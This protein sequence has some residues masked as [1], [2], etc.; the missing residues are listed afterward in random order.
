MASHPIL[1][2]IFLFGSK[3]MSDCEPSRVVKETGKGIYCPSRWN[4]CF[5]P[6]GKRVP[7]AQTIYKLLCVDL[8]QSDYVKKNGFVFVSSNWEFYIPVFCSVACLLCC[9]CL[10]PFPSSVHFLDR[11]HLYISLSELLL[12]DSIKQS[13]A[14][15]LISPQNPHL[16]A[17]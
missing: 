2:Y 4:F 10:E 3:V 6:K 11:R 7:V 15:L 12:T 5:C 1:K 13:S 16:G 8:N 9:T 17:S 14:V